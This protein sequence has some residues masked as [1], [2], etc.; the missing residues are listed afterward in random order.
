MSDFNILT[1]SMFYQP[2]LMM[3]LLS[4]SRKM[5]INLKKIVANFGITSAAKVNWGK[6]KVLAVGNWSSGLPRLPGGT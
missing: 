3:L 2:M 4:K 5:L 1:Q 6:S